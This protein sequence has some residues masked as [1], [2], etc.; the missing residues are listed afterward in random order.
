ME[1]PVEKIIE[2]PVEN[3][4]YVDKPYEKIVEVPYE[5]T[6]ENVIFQEKVIDVDESQVGRYQN[7]KVLETKVDYVH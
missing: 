2:V 6:R 3:K 4:V 7:A 1:V 5:V